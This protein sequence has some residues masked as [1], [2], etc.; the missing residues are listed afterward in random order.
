MWMYSA[1]TWVND[2]LFLAE[3]HSRASPLP[4]LSLDI[5][6]AFLDG[7][8]RYALVV[9][10]VELGQVLQE[11]MTVSFLCSTLNTSLPAY[12]QGEITYIQL[13]LFFG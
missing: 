7:E 13:C 1:H 5:Q 3:G 8:S 9:C 10:R 6:V 4:L 11:T 12:T 2:L